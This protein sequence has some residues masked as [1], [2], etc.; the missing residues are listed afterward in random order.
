MHKNNIQWCL[1]QGIVEKTA[2]V[3]SSLSSSHLWAR[4]SWILDIWVPA[5][6]QIH[7]CPMIQLAILTE[8]GQRPSETNLDNEGDSLAHGFEDGL[9][10]SQMTSLRI[11]PFTGLSSVGSA[12][13]LGS[14]VVSEAPECL[15]QGTKYESHV[16]KT[17]LQDM[18]QQKK[19]VFPHKFKETFTFHWL[20]LDYSDPVSMQWHPTEL[21]ISD[22]NVSLTLPAHRWLWSTWNV[23]KCGWG[24]TFHILIN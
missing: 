9:I 12:Y 23:A 6:L 3:L 1:A 14:K 2:E 20:W 22:G 4:C 11:W 21:S 5:F 8:K 17:S 10:L 18:I 13:L 7:E 24:N 16:Y 19:K 15:H